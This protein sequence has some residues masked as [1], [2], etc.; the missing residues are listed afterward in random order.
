MQDSLNG[1]MEGVVMD[2]REFHDRTE[3][4]LWIVECTRVVCLVYR[5]PERDDNPQSI[6]SLS[7]SNR[8][9]DLDSDRMRLISNLIWMRQP[10]ECTLIKTK[11]IYSTPESMMLVHL[12]TLNLVS[13]LASAR[14]PVEC[15]ILAQM[16]II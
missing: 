15:T 9:I 5:T 10:H 16:T 2:A 7:F 1:E 4:H 13:V 12:E 8:T 11:I 14:I 3:G 6:P